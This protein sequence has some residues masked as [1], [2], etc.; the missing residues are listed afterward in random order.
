MVLKGHQS[1][2]YRLEDNYSQLSWVYLNFMLLL[3]MKTAGVI[4]HLPLSGRVFSPPPL[5]GLCVWTVAN[6]HHCMA[7]ATHLWPT[8]TGPC[9][10][11]AVQEN[12]SIP[13]LTNVAKRQLVFTHLVLQDCCDLLWSSGVGAELTTWKSTPWCMR[14]LLLFFLTKLQMWFYCCL[15]KCVSWKNVLQDLE[16][17]Q[18]I[19][20]FSEVAVSSTAGKCWKESEFSNY[21]PKKTKYQYSGGK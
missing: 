13:R 18:L 9:H 19:P 20:Y 2:P 17:Q 14:M 11:S 15:Q 6:K 7:T 8:G 3:A 5:H 12:Q 4:L 21:W 1:P 10:S 16:M